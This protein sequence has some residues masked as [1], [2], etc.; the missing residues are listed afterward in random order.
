MKS[1]VLATV[2][3]IVPGFGYIYIGGK[4]RWFGVALVVAL[5]LS[6]YATLSNPVYQETINQALQLGQDSAQTEMVGRA[7]A[8]SSIASI[9]IVGA[10]MYDGY[11]SCQQANAV[12][13]AKIKAKIATKNRK[14]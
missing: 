1:L 7:G 8:L 3:N 4:K 11:I 6:F 14:S 2:L 13:D 12:Y 5:G 9:L 10:F